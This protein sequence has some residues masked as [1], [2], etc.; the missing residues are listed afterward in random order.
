M[1]IDDD[2]RL[3]KDWLRALDEVFQNPSVGLAGGPSRPVFEIQ[4]PHWLEEFYKEGD[5][6]RM[7]SFLSLLDCGGV[8]KDVDPNLIWGLNYSIR[9][10]TL[11]E[12]GG[13]HPDCIPKKLQRYQGDGEAGLSAKA[14]ARG[15][16]CVYHPHAAVRHEVS[17]SRLVPSYFETRSFYQ[18][19][20]DSF[21]EIRE[22][23][24]VVHQ[25]DDK[26]SFMQSMLQIS[27]DLKRKMIGPQWNMFERGR[28][29]YRAGYVFHQSE[30]A[31]DPSLLAW[32]LKDNYWDYNLPNGWKIHL[33]D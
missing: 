9:R 17:G 2:V 14:K 5:F 32:V 7:C 4:P 27:R 26:H 29:A 21:A 8:Q 20:C 15:I 33:S 12:L 18:G 28:H 31:G 23:R 10:R 25:N 6:G 19:V 24:R 3:G 1:F 30:V 13:F 11:F 22:A 16:R